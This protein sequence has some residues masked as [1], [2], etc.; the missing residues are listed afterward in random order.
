MKPVYIEVELEITP[1]TGRNS[2]YG[3]E[4]AIAV[5]SDLDGGFAGPEKVGKIP[6]P[7]S[8]VAAL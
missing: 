4:D 8:G 1:G 3:E 6:L 5:G 7:T 2:G